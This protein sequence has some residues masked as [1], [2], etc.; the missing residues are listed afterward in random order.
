MGLTAT[1]GACPVLAHK[2][3]EFA[4]VS[5]DYLLQG[6]YTG[7]LGNSLPLAAQVVA[8]GQNRFKAVF[9]KGGLPGAGWNAKDRDEVEGKT[10]TSV[11]AAS[12]QGGG[13]SA[14]IDANG[15]TMSGKISSGETFSL[16][17]TYRQSPTLNA[18]PPS[19][20]KILFDGKNLTAWK[21]GTADLTIDSLMKPFGSTAASGAITKSSFQNFTLHLEF[22]V[23]FMPLERGL[24]RGN[25]GIYLQGRYELQIL[26]SFGTD[27]E[28]SGGESLKAKHQC[29]SFFEY[30]GPSLNM[31]FPP[32]AWQTFDI[33]F[34]A[35]NYDA[36]GKIKLKPAYASIWLNGILVQEK[37]AVENAT[38]LGDLPGPEAG[39]LR[40]Q[41]YGDSVYFRNIWLTEG[42]PTLKMPGGKM[43][44]IGNPLNQK[45]IAW[46][47][48]DG[49]L[50]PAQDKSRLRIGGN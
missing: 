25:S 18:K 45:L 23:P 39:P 13:Y 29:G 7:T 35:A 4:P 2:S 31:S 43:A 49:R 19:G 17:K 5:S 16:T 40:F 6:E 14:T 28:L 1:L 27:L 48:M 46:T 3:L 21:E 26:D 9:F 36:G 10:L 32:L 44:R 12:F 34:T 50:V 24:D 42:I 47:R 11:Q 33:E 38:L 15:L 30:Y 37:R 8:L 20:A 22:R 41:A